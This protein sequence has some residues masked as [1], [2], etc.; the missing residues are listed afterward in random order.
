M[1]EGGADILSIDDIGLTEAKELVGDKVCL[2]GNVS[3]ADGMFKGNPGIITSMIKDC[4][5]KASDNPKGYIVATG[6]EVPIRTPHENMIAFL[7]AGRRF[8]RLPIN[9]N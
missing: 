6:C 1:A 7:E 5:S 3:P 2:M 8:A 9:L 4:L